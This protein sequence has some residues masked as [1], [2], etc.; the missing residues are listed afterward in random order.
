MTVLRLLIFIR[1]MYGTGV[2]LAL[3]EQTVRVC[4]WIGR[5]YWWL[6]QYQA[7]IS[8]S[9]SLTTMPVHGCILIFIWW[10]CRIGSWRTVRTFI[11]LEFDTWYWWSMY[12]LVVWGRN[13]T[14]TLTTMA[15]LRWSSS[16]ECIERCRVVPGCTA[17]TFVLLCMRLNRTMLLMIDAVWGYP[18]ELSKHT[19]MAM[20]VLSAL[21]SVPWLYGT[22][23]TLALDHQ[24]V[25]LYCCL[26]AW[27]WRRFCFWIKYDIVIPPSRSVQIY[28]NE[29]DD[30]SALILVRWMYRMGI[31][32]CWPWANSAYVYEVYCWIWH[33]ILVFD[34]G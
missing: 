12:E 10:M 34:A 33:V 14:R 26:R 22:G 7:V 13:F 19:A 8:S 11:L 4:A 24:R 17:R 16:V 3:N 5:C 6:I 25:C 30:G 15:V 1:S 27:D 31:V 2:V 23:V 29:N 18:Y 21:I 20:A 9:H 32:S 28:Y